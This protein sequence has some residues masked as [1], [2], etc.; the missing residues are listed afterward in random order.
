MHTTSPDQRARAQDLD[1]ERLHAL[2]RKTLCRGAEA[3][4][5][6]VEQV[7]SYQVL[8]AS[9]QEAVARSRLIPGRG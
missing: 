1:A 2:A 6:S 7:E 8:I 9:T 4:R 5:R 3:V